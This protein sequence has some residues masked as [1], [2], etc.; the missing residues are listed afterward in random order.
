MQSLVPGVISLYEHWGQRKCDSSADRRYVLHRK[1]VRHRSGST[2][3]SFSEAHPESWRSEFCGEMHRCAECAQ[4]SSSSSARADVVS[5]P[6][7]H[8]TLNSLPNSLHNAPTPH[9]SPVPHPGTKGRFSPLFL[10]QLFNQAFPISMAV[11]CKALQHVL[12]QMVHRKP[13]LAVTKCSE[14]TTTFLLLFGSGLI[15]FLWADC[16]FFYQTN[17]ESSKSVWSSAAQSKLALLIDT[18]F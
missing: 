2:G 1:P 18:C 6:W 8:C 15:F 11:S 5:S 16:G 3:K 14:L 7:G 17:L 12:F 9:L 13:I 10:E 4:Q